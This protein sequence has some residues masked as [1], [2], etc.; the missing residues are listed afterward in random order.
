M[1][2]KGFTVSKLILGLLLTAITLTMFVPIVNL[3]AKALSSPD[4]VYLMKGYDLLPKGFSLLHFKVVLSNPIVGKALLNSLFI[5]VTGTLLSVFFTTISAYVLTRKNL[6]GKAPLMVFLIIFMILEPGI[7]PEYMVM[8][9][10]RLLDSLWSMV[11]YRTINVFYLIIM[12]RF[13]EDVPDSL[14]E[15]A[16][17]DGA[18]HMRV[19]VRIVLP[20]AKVPLLTIGMFYAVSRWNEF[21][22]SSIF[23]SDPDKT[24]LQVLLRQFVV[25]NDSTALLS[26]AT[27]LSNN[28]VAQLDFS[29][30]K[31]ATIVIAMIPILVLYPII[32]KYYTSGVMEGGIKE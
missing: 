31:A 14:I 12:M 15:A 19:F 1:A 23:L 32:L 22:K 5:T 6:V 10:L 30:L 7:V 26:A 16:K 2:A 27:L 25:D 4:K 29:A 3:F 18:G 28:E 17:I 13:M 9:D 8:K 24:V 21:F 11:L 20:L